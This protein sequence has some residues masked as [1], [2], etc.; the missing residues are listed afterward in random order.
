MHSVAIY[1]C[2][3]VVGHIKHQHGVLNWILQ[4]KFSWNR[5]AECYYSC[6]FY[7]TFHV[8]KKETLFIS[9]FVYIYCGING[10][11]VIDLHVYLLLFKL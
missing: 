10:A 7:H 4:L 8:S 3:S 1:Y 2:F 11:I 5:L 9:C 6:Y